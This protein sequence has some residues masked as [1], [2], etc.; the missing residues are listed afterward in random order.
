M[1]RLSNLIDAV[2]AGRP[3]R[4]LDGSIAIWNFTNRCNLACRH[5]YSYADPNSE[6]FLST[7][8]IL[9]SIPELLKAGIRFVIFSGGE[10]L[11]RK[12]IF[13][14]A[15]A[16]R[17]VGIVTYLS[18]NGLYVNEKNVDR[19]I[20]TFN[21]I[22]ISIDGIEAVHDAFRGLE[23]AYRRSLDAIALIQQHGGNAGIRF[24]ITE[25]TKGSFYDIFDLAEEIGVDKIYISHLVY[26]GRGLDNL[27]ID[28]SPEERRKFVEFII[29]KAFQYHEEGRKIDVVTGNMEMDAILFLEKF[30]E[31]YPVLRDE[32]QRRLRNWGGNSAGR[33]LVNIDWKG[34]VKPDPFFPFVIGNMTEKPFSEIWLDG[35][36]EMLTRLREHPRKLS[37]KCADCSVIDICN[38]G[39]RSRAWAIH[40]DLWA[41][42]PSC[43][44]SRAEI[45]SEE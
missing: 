43:Y 18:T 7:E 5:C 32:M 8:F 19:I 33:K 9:D 38:G 41:E 37:G 13:E 1:F 30:G 27:K 11:I 40:G 28:I 26:S 42:D 31:R 29:D 36:N 17:E 24:T 14:I 44:L 22:G 3:E 15:E 2:T 12:D 4:S 21:Y 35:E 25:E 10:P 20:E 16:M 39:S 6:D 23:G 34:N 45:T